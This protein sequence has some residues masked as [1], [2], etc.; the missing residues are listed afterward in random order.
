MGRLDDIQ[1]ALKP[2][3]KMKYIIMT[4]LGQAE[5]FETINRPDPTVTLFDGFFLGKYKDTNVKFS[6]NLDSSL[7]FM[8]FKF[9]IYIFHILETS[10]FIF[11]HNFQLKG[12]SQIKMVSSERSDRD[13]SQGG[14]QSVKIKFQKQ[15]IFSRRHKKVKIQETMHIE[16][17]L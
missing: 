4:I 7:Q 15:Y 8:L 12:T 17:N 2:F 5:S 11:L 3:K 14:H 9:K 16:E 6:Y 13:L 10:R 1:T